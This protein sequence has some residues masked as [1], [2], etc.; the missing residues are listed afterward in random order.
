MIFII[1]LCS[2]A[3]IVAVLMADK[4]RRMQRAWRIFHF[5]ETILLQMPTWVEKTRY[6]HE[7]AE[8]RRRLMVRRL[9]DSIGEVDGTIM[10]WRLFNAGKRGESSL[11]DAAGKI[12][13]HPYDFSRLEPDLLH[14]LIEFDDAWLIFESSERAKKLAEIIRRR[15]KNG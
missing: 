11:R 13:N 2:I 7:C 12:T 3:V 1:V 10:D 8:Q 4:Y 14:D 9:R 6:L 5:D 15:R